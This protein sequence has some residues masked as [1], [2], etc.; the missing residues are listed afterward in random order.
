MPFLAAC[1]VLCA[2]LARLPLF[3]Y[4]LPLFLEAA[5]TYSLAAIV[6]VAVYKEQ[7]H[8]RVFPLAPLVETEPTKPPHFSTLWTVTR[9]PGLKSVPVN[10]TPATCCVEPPDVRDTVYSLGAGFALSCGFAL[11]MA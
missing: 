8:E 2:F 7:P 11:G 4:P 10:M 5:L 6:T 1:A 9:S 3:G